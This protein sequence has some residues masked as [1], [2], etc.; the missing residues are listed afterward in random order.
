[1]SDIYCTICG[2]EGI[3]KCPF[4]RSVFPKNQL[5]TMFQNLTDIQR[6]EKYTSITLKISFRSETT[7]DE[8]IKH[9]S[10]LSGYDWKFVLCNHVWDF[11]PGQESSIGCEHPG[12]IVEPSKYEVKSD[13]GG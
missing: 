9:M 5:G 7:D 4:C 11:M 12:N 8:I 2:E 1:M 13:T 10:D 3:S 6:T